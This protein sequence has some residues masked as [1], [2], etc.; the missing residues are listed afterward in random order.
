MD[1]SEMLLQ[2]SEDVIHLVKDNQNC[3]D[4]ALSSGYTEGVQLLLGMKK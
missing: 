2:G 1:E 3:L 4:L